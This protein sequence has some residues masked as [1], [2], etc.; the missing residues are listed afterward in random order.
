MSGER[1]LVK[2]LSD[3]PHA[4]CHAHACR[5]HAGMSS[6]TRGMATRQAVAHAR[7]TRWQ[8]L[9]FSGPGGPAE[10]RNSCNRRLPESPSDR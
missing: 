3:S 4:G 5:G 6:R 9:E 10:Q 1:A 8:P 2:Q 7:S